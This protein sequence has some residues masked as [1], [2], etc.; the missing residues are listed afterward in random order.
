MEQ[1]MD[2]GPEQFLEKENVSMGSSIPEE[3]LAV[4]KYFQE[5]EKERA[6]CHA[7]RGPTAGVSKLP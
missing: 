6:G 4:S 2:T 1:H 5:V 3:L 7:F